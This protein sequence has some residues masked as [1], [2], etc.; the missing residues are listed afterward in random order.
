MIEESVSRKSR[1]VP[2]T[3]SVRP[4]LPAPT[5][6]RTALLVAGLVSLCMHA[7]LIVLVYGHPLGLLD[8]ELLGLG[9]PTIEITR[10]SRDLVVEEPAPEAWT[11]VGNPVTSPTVAA[12]ARRESLPELSRT[13]LANLPA[14]RGAPA[15]ATNA[16]PEYGPGQSSAPGAGGATG[17][18]DAIQ[19]RHLPER[20]PE[21]M[22]GNPAASPPPW[23][24]TQVLREKVVATPPIGLAF[25]GDAPSSAGLSGKGAGAGSSVGTGTGD[26]AQGGSAAAARELLLGG[27]GTGGGG[28]TSSRGL[29]T[30]LTGV[31]PGDRKP[32]GPSGESAVDVAGVALQNTGQLPMP[33]H[34][35]NDFEYTLTT[36][37]PV[38]PED[39]GPRNFFRVD[40]TAKRSLQRINAMPKDMV[41]L[42]DVSGSIDQAWV[43]QIVAG[44][45]D[46]LNTLSKE[47]RFNVVFFNTQSVF[48]SVDGVKPATEANIAAAQQFLTAARSSGNTDVNRAL[49]RLL[50]RDVNAERVYNLVLISDGVPT[51]GVMDTRE[52]INLITKDNDLAASIYCVGV[53]QQQR[54]D[55]L[56]YLAYRNRG[57]CVYANGSRNAAQT[58]RELASALRYP[59]MKDVRL[60]VAGVDAQMVA[61]VI[62]PNIH[63]GQT[64]SVFGRFNNAVPFTMQLAGRNGGKAL[65]MTFRRDLSQ[66]VQG[67]RK[68]ATDWAFARLH[69]LYAVQIVRGESPELRA[70]IE[71][72]RQV[73]GLKTVY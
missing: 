26:D 54:R 72:L 73:F 45:K 48:F 71:Q 70:Q 67:D 62:L 50:V 57:W 66:A 37:Q 39:A 68:V 17:P 63:Q 11:T 5:R 2:P 21:N 19:L 41:Y 25:V 53:G 64:L 16:N 33:E 20:R 27:T 56:E 4:S 31:L 47:D 28:T 58:V 34:L 49:S 6:S 36:Y 52:L 65:D 29:P 60:N 7:V 24:V 18:G 23:D 35:D 43:N 38:R 3:P 40:I 12:S 42:I 8:P 32:G 44:V 9:K 69:Y 10:D 30:G 46:A 1:P 22:T 14:G 55:L 51:K 13:M 61:P 15:N 59:I